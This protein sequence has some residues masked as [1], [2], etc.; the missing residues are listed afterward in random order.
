[1]KDSLDLVFQA[2]ADPTRRAILERLRSCDA[3]VGELAEPFA[4]SLQAVSRHLQVLERAG[5]V[6]RAREAQWRTAGL[7]PRPLRDVT[8]WL[9]PFTRFWAGTE[10]PEAVA[11][12]A[13]AGISRR[14]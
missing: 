3:T 14:R 10:V 2:L 1:M 11:E 13:P 12:T 5:L 8:A 7:D 6:V 4:M 9:G